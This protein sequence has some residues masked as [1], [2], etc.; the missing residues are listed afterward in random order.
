VNTSVQIR[1]RENLG[2]RMF[3]LRRKP[4]GTDPSEQDGYPRLQGPEFEKCW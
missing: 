1:F 3:S 4:V 2:E